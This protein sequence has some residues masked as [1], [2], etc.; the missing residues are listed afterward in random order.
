MAQQ[1]EIIISY[2]YYLS[3]ELRLIFIPGPIVLEID[4]FFTK[5]PFTV[6]GFN[7][8]IALTKLFKFSSNLSSL[9]L[10]LPIIL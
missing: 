10:T 1:T 6:A 7:Y 2:F 9:K 3:N 4:I 5:S 8:I